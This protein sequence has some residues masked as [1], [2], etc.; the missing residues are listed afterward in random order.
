M[1]NRSLAVLFPLVLAAF[2]SCGH[3]RP[4][5]LRGVVL[6]LL[7]TVRP[8]HLSAYGYARD[9]SPAISRLAET[10]VLFEQ[11]ASSAPWTLPA[12][13]TI[14]SGSPAPL[15]FSKRLTRSGVEAFRR[16]DFV[17][18]AFTEGA[19]LSS[20]YGFALGFEHYVEEK[21]MTAILGAEG[22]ANA[23]SLVART[24]RLASEWVE[25]NRRDRFFLLIHTYEPHAPYRRRSFAEGLPTGAMG[26]IFDVKQLGS[27]REGSVSFGEVEL[28]YL[29]AL[30]DGGVLET[31]RQV[32]AFLEH[33]ESLGIRDE[34]LVVLTSDH[35]EELGDHYRSRCGDHGHSLLDDLLKVPL[36]IDDPTRSFPV[37]TVEV[38]V[39]T[40]DIM[41]TLLDLLG[42]P[43][44]IPM[45]GRSLVPLMNGQSEPPRIAYG[46]SPHSGPD[47]GYVRHRGFKYIR[48]IDPEPGIGGKLLPTPPPEQ[49]YDLQKDPGE[50]YNLAREQPEIAAELRKLL[51]EL[52]KGASPSVE[53]PDT[54]DDELRR[55]LESLGYVP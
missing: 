26:E 40:M 42:V 49:L 7:D 4:G 25:Q 6:I 8:D 30:Y 29:E 46:G 53:M 13:V 37:K 16:A 51:E 2:V 44:E 19:F 20:K 36:I 54:L 3:S 18:A 27:L 23:E 14:F 17:T 12:A 41:P 1:R 11:V 43:S 9:T 34:T 35:G 33:L 21:G 38:Q 55:R 5:E 24:F 45:E 39:R 28:A 15:R 31:D 52:T 32:G 10:G 50:L 47:R 48:V 22:K